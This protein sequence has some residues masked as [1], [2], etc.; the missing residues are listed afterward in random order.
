M[1]GVL[2]EPVRS[3]AVRD[4]GLAAVGLLRHDASPTRSQE[5]GVVS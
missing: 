1:R 5:S 2:D 3:T 4:E